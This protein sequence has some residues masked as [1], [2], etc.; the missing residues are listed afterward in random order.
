MF[1]SVRPFG[2]QT[3][4]KRL[5][6]FTKPYIDGYSYLNKTIV[7]TRQFENRSTSASITAALLVADRGSVVGCGVWVNR[8]GVRRFACAR[9]SS[10][11]CWEAPKSGGS[12]PAFRGSKMGLVDEG[13]GNGASARTR[14]DVGWGG[15][16]KWGCT[17]GGGRSL[18]TAKRRVYVTIY[19]TSRLFCTSWYLQG[20]TTTASHIRRVVNE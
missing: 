2:R 14:G 5:K 13:A 11:A 18:G 17:F 6:F 15:R 7:S 3:S 19:C 20:I 1:S 9:G 16:K 4:L 10:V 12:A 8:H